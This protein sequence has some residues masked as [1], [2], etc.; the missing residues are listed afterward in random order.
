MNYKLLSIIRL[1]IAIL[2]LF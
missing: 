2:Y 1:W